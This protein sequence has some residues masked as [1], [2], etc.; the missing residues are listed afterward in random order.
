MARKTSYHHGNLRAALLAA[1]LEILE[2][3]ILPRFC[4]A[5]LEAVSRMS[6]PQL[7]PVE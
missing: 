1:A 4:E 2:R 5:M 7:P 6:L 3:D